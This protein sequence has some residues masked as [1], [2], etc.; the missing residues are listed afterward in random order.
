MTGSGNETSAHLLENGRVT[1][2]FC[3]F[4]GPPNILRLYGTGT[5]ILPGS[6]EWEALYPMFTPLPGARQIILIDVHK[7]QTS[8]GFSVPFMSYES[9][10]DTLQRWSIQKGEEGLKAYRQEKNS[11]SID[12]LK[13][14]LGQKN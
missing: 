3:A 13:T 1:V 12:G 14:P 10:R 6:L 11:T 7:V 9:E 2:M 8:C 5:V 4:E